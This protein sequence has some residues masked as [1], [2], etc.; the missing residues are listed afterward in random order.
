[1]DFSLS[2]EQAMLLE[3][4]R[5]MGK[6]ENFKELAVEIDKTG[7]FPHELMKKYAKMD[8][9]GMTL[10]AEHGGADMDALTAILAIEELAKFSPMIAA[11]VFES[12]VGPARVISLFGTEEQKKAV[13]PG[14]CSGDL[15]V[16]VCMTEPQAGSDLTSLDTN[17]EEKDGHYVLNGTKVFITGGGMASHY[18]VYTRFEGIKGHKGIGAVLVESGAEGFTFGKQEVF[19]GLRGMPSC[20]LYFDN[21]KIPKENVVIKA[22]DFG[23]LMLAFDIERC[24]NAA[25]C[26][27]TAG[28]A[29]EEARRYAMERQAFGR[30]ICEFQGLQFTFAD[31]AMKLDAARLLVYRAAS[32][33]GQGLPSIYEASMG[34][35]YANEMVK[36]VTDAALQILGGYGYSTD[37]PL[38]RMV[39][40]ARAW[41]VAGGSLQMLRVTIA[42]VLFGRRFNQR[43]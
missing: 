6:R 30:P 33:A 42:S 34:K 21:V 3:S 22:G 8:L 37:Y 12:N 2:K 18:L 36:E 28:G 25:M 17:V 5:D 43:A 31:M 10:S 40:D 35:C 13:I 4:L 11:P 14:V 26:L 29:F 23:K 32:G 27:G 20:A 41:Q 1:M 19:L 15:S 9:L 38:E 7:E 39:R 24:G 16:S